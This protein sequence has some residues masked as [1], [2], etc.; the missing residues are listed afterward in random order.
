MSRKKD[1]F[2]IGFSASGKSAVGP[3]LARLLKARF[4][5]T[6]SVVE[7]REGQ[8]I[9]GV[10]RARG[11]RYFRRIEHS[12]IEGLIR[13][14]SRTGRRNVVALGGGAFGNRTLRQQVKRAGLVI[15]LSCSAREIYRRLREKDD[16][17]LMNVIP[18]VGESVCEARRNRIRRLLDKR[19]PQYCQADLVYSTTGKS[20]R[21]AARG[22]Y[23]LLKKHNEFH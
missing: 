9:D 23:A 22:L 17:P 14:A 18:R 20:P 2:L 21:R 16:R 19:L 3:P 4:V 15:F 5:D 12:V 7:A 1:V 10:F 8:S 13:G 6:D 11:E